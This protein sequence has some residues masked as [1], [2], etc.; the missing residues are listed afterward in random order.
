MARF[1]RPQNLKAFGAKVVQIACTHAAFAAVK[2]G[3]RTMP[4]PVNWV[5]VPGF[6]ATLQENGEV[7]TWG[8]AEFGGDSSSVSEFLKD[9]CLKHSTDGGCRFAPVL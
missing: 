8:D 2:V 5:C 6:D 9:A 1:S 3:T 7:V 4:V